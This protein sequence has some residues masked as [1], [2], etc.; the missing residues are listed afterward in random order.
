MDAY[1]K[2]QNTRKINFR[3]GI[4]TY[5]T[6]SHYNFVTSPWTPIVEGCQGGPT[7]NTIV[8]NAYLEGLH[9]KWR[10]V[11]PV[12]MILQLTVEFCTSWTV[13]SATP[14]ELHLHRLS[15]SPTKDSGFGARG[16]NTFGPSPLP[17]GQGSSSG[18]APTV[19]ES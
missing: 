16:S 11:S 3:K 12:G 4:P 7:P 6:H 5:K 13:C 10:N 19:V 9:W 2:S 14:V 17:L 15:G 8:Y 18:G 1:S